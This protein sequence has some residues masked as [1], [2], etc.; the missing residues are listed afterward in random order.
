MNLEGVEEDEDEDEERENAQLVGIDR[1]S[2]RLFIWVS[3]S[4]FSV[5]LVNLWLAFCL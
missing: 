4:W 5:N 3:F 2:G 1:S